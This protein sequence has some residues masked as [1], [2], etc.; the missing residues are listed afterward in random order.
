MCLA[1]VVLLAAC[2]SNDSLPVIPSQLEAS[3]PT[4]EELPL[5]SLPGVW[6]GTPALTGTAA[7]DFTQT[8][9]VDFSAVNEGEAIVSHWYTDASTESAD[10]VVDLAY[11]YLCAGTQLILKPT[12]T[13]AAQGASRLIGIYAGEGNLHLYTGTEEGVSRVACLTRSD[14][15]PSIYAD[16]Q[17]V[18]V[19]PTDRKQAVVGFGGM[20][21]PYLWAGSNVLNTSEI[22][23][24]YSPSGMGYTLLRLMIYADENAWGKDVENA[25]LAQS[26]GATVFACPWDCPAVWSDSV[27]VYGSR[28]KHLLHE[29]YADYAN[30]LCKF[31]K[32]MRQQGVNL[33]GITVQNEPNGTFV[34][35]SNDELAAFIRSYGATIRATGVRLMAPEPEGVSLPYLRAVTQ[36]A[37]VFAQ[38]D[39]IATHTYTGYIGDSDDCLERREYLTNLYLTQLQAEGKSWWMTEHL[40]NE[41]QNATDEAEQLYRRWDYSLTTLAREIHDCMTTYCS[42][43]CYWYLKRFYGLMGDADDRS[44]VPNGDITA[45]GY[46]LAHYARY[47]SG[48]Q[49]IG[50]TA[51][52]ADLTAT[53]YSLS[54]TEHTLVLTN[55][56]QDSLALQITGTGATRAEAKCSTE[57]AKMQTLGLRLLGGRVYLT[58]PPMSITSVRCIQ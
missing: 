53:A 40:F 56:T 52:P 39:D 49:R 3:L 55:P 27:T 9:E 12:A 10:S 32:Y 47:A 31:V 26:L 24:L 35:W 29:H 14:A 4:G 54:D 37:D 42:A 57:E 51:D 36:D 13:A 58:L 1:V 28:R 7:D 30:H 15:R 38:V 44:P 33:Y 23:K 16:W 50:V 43:Y 19:D 2:H 34:Y 11:T 22:E 8:Y 5:A 21:N 20:L 45:N 41:G 48:S 46:I 17:T 6:R 25:L 18:S